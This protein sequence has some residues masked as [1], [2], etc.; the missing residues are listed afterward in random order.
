VQQPVPA[1]RDGVVSALD[2]LEIGLVSK[3]L[4]AGRDRKEDPI[5][6]S[7]GIVLHR[8][9]GDTVRAGDPLATVHAARS[10]QFDAARERLATAFQIGGAAEPPRLILARIA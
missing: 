1:P 5:D 6:V 8:K 2:A 4:G 9:V 7:V 10:D 3:A